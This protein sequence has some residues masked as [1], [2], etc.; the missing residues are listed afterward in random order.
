M[1]QGYPGEE[2]FEVILSGQELTVLI[3]QL[4]LCVADWRFLLIL[5]LHSDELKTSG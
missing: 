3:S 5:F 4:C 2:C 1:D